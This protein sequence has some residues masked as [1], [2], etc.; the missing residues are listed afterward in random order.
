MHAE[1]Q[2]SIQIVTQCASTAFGHKLVGPQTRLPTTL[3]AS[4]MVPFE[5]IWAAAKVGWQH[6]GSQ[7]GCKGLGMGPWVPFFQNQHEKIGLG[8]PWQA[9]MVPQCTMRNFHCTVANRHSRNSTKQAAGFYVVVD[10][11][12]SYQIPTNRY[13][14]SLMLLI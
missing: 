1:N 8:W 13:S 5:A 2:L 3:H 6:V 10:I 14:S 4:N 7:F 9:P 11:H 12:H